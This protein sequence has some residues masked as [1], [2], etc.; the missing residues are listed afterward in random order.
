M[1]FSKN[2]G[3]Q[4]FLSVTNEDP[5]AFPGDDVPNTHMGV[6]TSRDK[7]SSSSGESANR[8]IMPLQMEFM[9]W[10]LVH[11]LLQMYELRQQG[12][13]RVGHIHTSAGSTSSSPFPKHLYSSSSGLGSSQTR[14][15]W[16]RLPVTIIGRLGHFSRRITPSS[17][18]VSTHSGLTIA[19]QRTVLVWPPK[20][21]VQRLVLRSQIRTVRS[22]EPLT[23]TS[24]V[25]D[26]AHTPPSC[27][28]R[29]I[30]N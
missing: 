12:G 20:T 25:A 4:A 2:K 21:C 3:E 5:L 14:R 27:P 6:V 11:I 30:V 7:C 16:S 8:M 24:F 1:G 13:A 9:V 18:V 26:N 10:V 19:R 29:D 17:P 15:V 22:V 23:R 28:S